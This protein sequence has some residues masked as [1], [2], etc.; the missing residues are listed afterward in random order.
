MIGFFKK[1]GS[2][3]RENEKAFS[4]PLR[5]LKAEDGFVLVSRGRLLAA[6]NRGKAAQG[7]EGTL[8]LSV[9]EISEE[10]TEWE[11]SPG[12]G[13]IFWKK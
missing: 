12:S 13:G 6:V 7:V 1:L 2:I 11:L 8:L 4:E 9:G 3:R 10:G 5:F